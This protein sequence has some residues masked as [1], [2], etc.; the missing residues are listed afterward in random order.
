MVLETLDEVRYAQAAAVIYPMSLIRVNRSAM[1]IQS[2]GPKLAVPRIRVHSIS[3]RSQ[4][5]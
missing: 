2:L 1:L 5:G 4:F 3:A